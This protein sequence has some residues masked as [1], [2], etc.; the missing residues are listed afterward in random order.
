MFVDGRGVTDGDELEADVAIVGSGA[1]GI[2][3]AAGG[4][5]GLR[6]VAARSGGTVLHLRELGHG[7]AADL[8]G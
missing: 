2:T 5:H 7:E 1:A 4:P 8:V 6:V 3:L